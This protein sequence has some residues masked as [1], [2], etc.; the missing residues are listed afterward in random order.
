[1][2][3]AAE[4]RG[5]R[6]KPGYRFGPFTIVPELLSGKDDPWAHRKG[7][8][9]V[10][11]LLWAMYLMGG[12]LTTIFAVRSVGAPAA[13]RYE[14][15]CRAMVVIVVCGLSVLWP[16]TRLS[17]MPPERPLRAMLID[18]V[19]LL[20]PVQAVVWPM[21]LLTT[22]TL[23]IAAGLNLMI[24]SWGLLA[25]VLVAHG[26]ASRSM[27]TRT[28]LMM[29]AVFLAGAAPAL[30]LFIGSAGSP[31][32]PGWWEMLSPITAT[33]A[34]T[35]APGNQTPQMSGLEWIL[36]GAP[37]LVALV[38]L[39]L[40]RPVLPRR[41]GPEPNPDGEPSSASDG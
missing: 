36:A 29:G 37:L 7:E 28:L 14:Y 39:S 33:L 24:A 17:Q 21:P 25:G 26:S 4:K 20:A 34:L 11:V 13:G 8:P 15:G 32:M 19:A 23:G 18:L 5:E 22:W 6:S 3:P 2:T 31:S 27:A 35:E 41:G 1:M 12:A 10:L 38:L 9:R 30:A 40:L 16:M